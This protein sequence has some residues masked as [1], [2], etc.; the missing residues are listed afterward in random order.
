VF[1]SKPHKPTRGALQKN[2]FRAA[3]ADP[4]PR[5]ANVDRWLVRISHVSQF[6]LFAL[7]IGALYFTV[8]PLYKTAA[9]EEAIAKR[10]AE[11]RVADERLATTQ[12]HLQA[13]N[14]RLYRRER[15]EIARRFALAAGPRCSGAFR[16]PLEPDL[17]GPRP[18]SRPEL[19]IAE[20]V[21]DCLGQE[22]ANV[23]PQGV[24]KEADAAFLEAAVRALGNDFEQLRAR[25][26][27]DIQEVRARAAADPSTLE[28]PGPLEKRAEERSAR[29]RAELAR[30][31]LPIPPDIERR[32][33]RAIERTQETIAR[34]FRNEV[35]DKV[36]ALRA[37][38]WPD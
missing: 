26:R 9:L 17:D 30:V 28:P 29:W 25:A 6:G 24:L 31:G 14:E 38:R 7:T 10:E 8:I 18:A 22:L 3:D 21:A 2:R 19:L 4:T 32:R 13:A 27:Q 35:L 33:E 12:A 5:E 11:L 34:K 36:T 20:N 1:R 15:D 23:Q 16:Q 37:F